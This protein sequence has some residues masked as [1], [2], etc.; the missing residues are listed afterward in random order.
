MSL[1]HPGGRRLLVGGNPGQPAEER[2]GAVDRGSLM[3]RGQ[4]AGIPSGS[5]DA[6]VPPDLR[7]FAIQKIDRLHLSR[8]KESYEEITDDSHVLDIKD[9]PEPL[10]CAFGKWPC[11]KDCL[12]VR[13]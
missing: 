13:S 7:R 10:Q 5:R 9:E 3:P 2:H 4:P 6:V 11:R 1:I 8:M 12:P